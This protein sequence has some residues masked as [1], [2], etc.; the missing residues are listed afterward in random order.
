MWASHIGGG[1]W[2]AHGRGGGKNK[3]E[4][5]LDREE[6]ASVWRPGVE[7]NDFISQ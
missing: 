3:W 5:W 4:I 6:E 7:A 1:T 2:K